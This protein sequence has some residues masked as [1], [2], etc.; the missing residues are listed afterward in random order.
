MSSARRKSRSR[1]SNSKTRPQPEADEDNIDVDGVTEELSGVAIGQGKTGT[2][3]TAQ[4]EAVID[5]ERDVVYKDVFDN[6]CDDCGERT[7][8]IGKKHCS[9]CERKARRR[10]QAPMRQQARELERSLKNW[11]KDA[12]MQ[13]KMKQVNERRLAQIAQLQKQFNGVL[14]NLKATVPLKN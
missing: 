4:E 8:L 6:L 12:A 1:G 13:A 14:D 10:A 9:A 7:K 2:A 3:K 11:K 5:L